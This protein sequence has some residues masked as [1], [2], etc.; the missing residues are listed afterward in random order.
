MTFQDIDFHIELFKA[1]L[2]PIGSQNEILNRI[3][4]KS[5]YSKNAFILKLEQAYSNLNEAWKLELGKKRSFIH[6]ENLEGFGFPISG[7]NRYPQL[8]DFSQ[9]FH[10]HL[11]EDN[12]NQISSLVG[13]LKIKYMMKDLNNMVFEKSEAEEKPNNQFENQFNTMPIEEVRKHFKPLI[14][15]KKPNGE[16]WMTEGDFEIFMKRS[17][18]GQTELPKPKINIGGTGKFAVVK[19]FYQFY[20]KSTDHPYNGDRK[21]DPFVKLLKDAFENSNFNELTNDNF[22]GDKNKKYEWD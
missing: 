11:T 17:F 1:F 18:G 8:I 16:M 14:E 19:L 9:A 10:G 20:S 5:G 13:S 15:R 21:K 4:K 12:L 7:L 6:P 2:E 3:R 22:K